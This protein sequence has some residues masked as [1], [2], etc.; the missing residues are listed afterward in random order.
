[1]TG[2]T[3]RPRLSQSERDQR[4]LDLTKKFLNDLVSADFFNGTVAEGLSNRLKT[5]MQER[6]SYFISGNPAMRGYVGRLC[7]PHIDE[8]IATCFDYQTKHKE[9]MSHYDICVAIR[10]YEGAQQ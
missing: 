8:F 1:M 6:F 4:A 7:I 9:N 3:R 10:D 2:S 5:L